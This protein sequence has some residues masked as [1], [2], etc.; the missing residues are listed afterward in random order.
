MKT[1]RL[2]V[3]AALLLPA[4]VSQAQTKEETIT[5]LKEKLGK[6]LTQQF[7]K[8][9]E[10][11]N[12]QFVSI[13]ECEIKVT[14]EQKVKGYINR[15]FELKTLIFPTTDLQYRSDWGI[16]YKNDVVK[17]IDSKGEI[18]YS[19]HT[20]IEITQ[21]EENIQERIQKAIAHLATFCP[22]KTEAF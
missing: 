6:Y 20:F 16:F 1:I 14:F 7:I 15:P 8:D 21:R 19:S 22:K 2:I 9:I 4:L 5:W 11:R 13:D 10:Y 17:E 18:N 3:L 12:F